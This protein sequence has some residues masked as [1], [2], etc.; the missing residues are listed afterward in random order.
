ME[1]LLN[2]WGARRGHNAN[3]CGNYNTTTQMGISHKSYHKGDY[4]ITIQQG[5]SQHSQV[6]G[7]KNGTLQVISHNES[8]ID[9]GCENKINQNGN[10]NYSITKGSCNT[11]SQ[12]SDEYRIYLNESNEQREY[13]ADDR[14]TRSNHEWIEV[15]TNYWK[16]AW[17]NNR[18][19]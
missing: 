17:D 16:V 14:D 8:Y 7:H 18:E 9:K 12:V 13:V 1:L 10:K 15:V 6:E 2:L 5:T 11:L 19:M 3:N 4:N